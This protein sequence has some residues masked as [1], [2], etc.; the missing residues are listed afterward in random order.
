MLT[1]IGALLF[2]SLG[3]GLAALLTDYKWVSTQTLFFYMYVC[4]S[5][6]G[7]AFGS[8]VRRRQEQQDK[9]E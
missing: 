1:F 4:V 6:L 5:A 2:V 9:G 3:T 7:A 8:R